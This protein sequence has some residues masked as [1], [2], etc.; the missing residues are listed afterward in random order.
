M[1]RNVSELKE[2]SIGALDGDI[3]RVEEL[4]FDDEAWGIRYLVVSTSAPSSV[5]ATVC[6]KCA[7]RD[8]SR[9]TTGHSPRTAITSSR[10][11]TTS[12]PTRSSFRLK[13]APYAS[14]SA[15]PQMVWC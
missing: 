14:R 2:C 5:T 1:L 12:S 7:A 8:P 15:T 11:S 4:Y 6:S 9:V 10:C 13:A 3:G